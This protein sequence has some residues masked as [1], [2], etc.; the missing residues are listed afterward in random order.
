[1]AEELERRGS[2]DEFKGGWLGEIASGKGRPVEHCGVLA[3]RIERLDEN[4]PAH[5]S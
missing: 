5:F 3:Q 1:M 4:A 2:T